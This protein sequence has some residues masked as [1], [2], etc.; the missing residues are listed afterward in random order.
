MGNAGWFDGDENESLELVLSGRTSATVH[1]ANFEANIQVHI[2][3]YSAYY[4]CVKTLIF[5]IKSFYI[6]NYFFLMQP[7][8]LASPL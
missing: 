2:Q 8:P 6:L 5:A 7:P 1:D 3:G 4:M